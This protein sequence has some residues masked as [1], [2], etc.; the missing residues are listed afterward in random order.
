MMLRVTDV[1]TRNLISAAVKHDMAM[2]TDRRATYN[3]LAGQMLNKLLSAI[4]S[5]GVTFKIWVD[6]K[7]TFDCTSLMGKEKQKLL[8]CLPEK[9]DSCQPQ[10]Y[11]G[12]VPQIW[13]V[14]L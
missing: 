11:C 1:L 6:K 5:C 9:L 2:T 3:I 12:V 7:N 14:Q 10:D 8:E 13:K 4:R